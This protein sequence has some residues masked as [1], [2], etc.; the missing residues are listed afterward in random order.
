CPDEAKAVLESASQRKIGGSQLHG[1]LAMVAL[2]QGDMAA[3]D[4]ELAALKGTPQ[5]EL[6]ILST[7]MSL[8]AS[9]G[10]MRRARELT[11][12]IIE[13]LHR[14][15]LNEGEA[16]MLAQVAMLEAAF[17]NRSRAV[18]QATKALNSSHSPDVT[19]SAAAALALAGS[20]KK[21][22][23]LV[24]DVAERRPEDTIVQ[25]VSV[26]TVQAIL[27]MNRG[28]YAKANQLMNAGSPYDR[29]NPGSRYIRAEAYRLSGRSKEAVQEYEQIL[30]LRSFMPTD[31]VLSLAHLGLARAYAAE[32][33]KSKSRIAYQNFLALW[34]DADPDI[35]LFKEAQTEY[36][37]LQ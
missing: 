2:A 20:D 23:D 9:H 21:A 3:L 31:P 17:R 19:I 5:G 22:R 12:R 11:A 15:N 30:N 28:D 32:G 25:Y 8:A 18:E 29:V 1:N 27:E 7:E 14:L 4:R 24:A 35:P 26:P 10:Q 36:A 34:K 37:K 33:D 6:T 16:A 13:A